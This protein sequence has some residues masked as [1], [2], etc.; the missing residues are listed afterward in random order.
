[1]KRVLIR[2][3]L[4]ICVVSQMTHIDFSIPLRL[5]TCC[6]IETRRTWQV[7]STV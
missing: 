3:D 2:Q 7:E 1:L 5:T 6:A 4:T